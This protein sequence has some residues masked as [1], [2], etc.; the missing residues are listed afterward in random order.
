MAASA[1][2]VLT[3]KIS[4]EATAEAAASINSAFPRAVEATAFLDD[5]AAQLAD[6][7]LKSDNSIALVS[8]CRDEASRVLDAVIAEKFGLIFNLHGLA[9]VPP[10]G[11]L[12]VK[13]G[14]SHSPVGEDGKE[15]YIFFGITHIGIDEK[16]TVGKMRRCGRPSPSGACGALLYLAAELA[17]GSEAATACPDDNVELFH[18]RRKVEAKAPKGEVVSVTQAAVEVI[19]ETLEE[20]IAKAVDTG[21]ADYAV[22]TGIQ[23]HTGKNVYDGP[24]SYENVGEYFV[25]SRAYAVVGGEKM[26]LRL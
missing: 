3:N 22:V 1:P 19:N 26:E 25:P 9:G 7:G 18:L 21:K 24:F 14:C 4:K 10:G 15:R 8:S 13:A 6:L 20:T 5:I 12:A 16:G 23:I 11:V 2:I 17:K